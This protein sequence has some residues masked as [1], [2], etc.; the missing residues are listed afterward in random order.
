M[1][2]RYL[3]CAET[4]KLIRGA[5]KREFSGVKFSVKSKTYS[6]GASIT[7]GW[8]DGPT[9]KAVDAVVQVYSGAG[10]DGMIDLKYYKSAWLLPDGSA[11]FA[12]T[13]GTSGSMGTVDSDQEMQHSFK[14]EQVHFGA[15]YVFTNRRYSMPVYAAAVKKLCDDYGQPMPEIVDGVCGPYIKSNDWRFAD[16]GQDLSTLVYRALQEA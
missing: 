2:T 3:S 16:T 10:F 5:L 11:T 14:A 8:T 9:G 6:G 12:K 13:S 1:T 7:V 4:A 15:D